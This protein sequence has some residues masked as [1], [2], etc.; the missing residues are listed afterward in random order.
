MTGEWGG[1]ALPSAEGGRGGAGLKVNPY[2]HLHTD[3]CD[4]TWVSLARDALPKHTLW[5]CVHQ[6]GGLPFILLP[7]PGRGLLL[8]SRIPACGARDLCIQ[9]LQHS[10]GLVHRHTHCCSAP[11]ALRRFSELAQLID[12]GKEPKTDKPSILQVLAWV[13]SAA[14]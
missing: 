3:L 7:W 14:Q 9:L 11:L 1:R 4:H 8:R 12:P 13:V 6:W 2:A 5:M 10:W